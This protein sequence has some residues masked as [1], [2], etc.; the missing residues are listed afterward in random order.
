MAECPIC[1]QQDPAPFWKWSASYLVAGWLHWTTSIMEGTISCSCL[2][3]YLVWMEIYLS[4]M[5]CFCENSHPSIYT[6]LYPSSWYSTQHCFW[7]RDLLHDKCSNGFM[8]IEFTV[9]IVFPFGKTASCVKSFHPYSVIWEWALGL[10]GPLPSFLITSLPSDK[11]PTQPVPDLSTCVGIFF[12]V[13]ISVRVALF[14]LGMYING[15]QEEPCVLVFQIPWRRD[16]SPSNVVWEIYTQTN[17]PSSACRSRIGG[18]GE[19]ELASHNGWTNAHSWRWFCSISSLCKWSPIPPMA[20]LYF[21][22]FHN[23]DIKI[24]VFGL[25]AMWWSLLFPH[26]IW[27]LLCHWLSV[28]DALLYIV[29]HCEAADL[30][31]LWNS[32]LKTQLQHQLCGCVLKGWGKVHWKTVFA[33]NQYSAYGALFMIARIHR[34][35]DIK[36]QGME[37]Q[38]ALLLLPVM[39]KNMFASCPCNHDSGFVN[40]D[41]FGWD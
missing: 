4:W 22:C 16:Q 33:L 5:Q 2:N 34:N 18:G 32:I 37:I 3:R 14:Y 1:H 39:H 29:H 41:V 13:S 17:D 21:V 10:E 31:K 40:D 24:Q 26:I 25:L 36:N 6:I 30:I 11:E 8:V 27:V 12:S 38:L 35:R 23:F 9:L 20:W 19:M 15:P 28:Q 7:S